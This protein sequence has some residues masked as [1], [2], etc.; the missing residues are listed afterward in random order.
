MKQ[1]AASLATIKMNFRSSSSVGAQCCVLCVPN[2]KLESRRGLFQPTLAY[3]AYS[4][5]PEFEPR[6]GDMYLEFLR[7]SPQATLAK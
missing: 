3:S 2:L 7:G 6:P 5:G 4:G 1:N